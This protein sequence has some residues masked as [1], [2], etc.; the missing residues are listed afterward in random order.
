VTIFAEDEITDSLSSASPCA[1]Q[2]TSVID[3]DQEKHLLSPF[4]SKAEN[5]SF[6][7]EAPLK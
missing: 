5:V 2:T 6:V 4:A 3:D 1:S 7:K